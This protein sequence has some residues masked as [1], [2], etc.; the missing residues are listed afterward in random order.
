MP[1]L[2]NILIICFIMLIMYQIVLA[3]PIIE[4]LDNN[5]STYQP[6]DTNNSSNAL[7]LA[8]QNAGNISYLKQRMDA[9]Q[10]MSQ[11]FQNTKGDVVTLQGQV[12]NLMAAQK[13][14]ATQVAGGPPPDVSGLS[15]TDPS[16]DT[17]GAPA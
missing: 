17:T 15:D 16:K 1:T 2:I 14:Y 11:Q 9:I 3:T 4:G 6:Y 10:D 13:S 7:I 12:S 8:Q 5:D